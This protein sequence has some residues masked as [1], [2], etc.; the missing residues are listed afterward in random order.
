MLLHDFSGLGL[1]DDDLIVPTRSYEV[2]SALEEGHMADR[3]SPGSCCHNFL[4]R[5]GLEAPDLERS[6][7]RT[8]SKESS[9]GIETAGYDIGSI[10][11]QA[12]G[13][14]ACPRIEQ[15]NGMVLGDDVVV[16]A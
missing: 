10:V 14:S 16:P 9:S 7:S 13:R 3:Q 1:D 11:A 5:N 4:R 6:V 12:S 15:V 8:G 2:R